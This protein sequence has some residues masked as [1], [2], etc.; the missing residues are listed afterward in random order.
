MRLES[1]RSDYSLVT[2]NVECQPGWS[3]LLS[4]PYISTDRR[5]DSGRCLNPLATDMGRGAMHAMALH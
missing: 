4:L 3:R 2:A 5:N 1:D